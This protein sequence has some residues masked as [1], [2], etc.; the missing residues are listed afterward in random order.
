MEDLNSVLVFPYV[1]R[2]DTFGEDE[3]TGHA[4]IVDATVESLR[5]K[6]Q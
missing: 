4:L 2:V 5:K 1:G 6:D 3:D